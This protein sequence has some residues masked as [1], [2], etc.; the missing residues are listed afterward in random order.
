[1]SVAPDIFYESVT[2]PFLKEIRVGNGI[3]NPTV[4]NKLRQNIETNLIERAIEGNASAFN[5]IYLAL[6]DSIYGFSYRML[7][8]SSLAE[9]ITQEAFIFFIE[10]PEKYQRERGSLLSFLCGYARNRIMHLLRKQGSRSEISQDD[11]DDYIEPQNESGNDPLKILLNGELSAKIEESIAKLP[12][13]QRE[14]IVLRA[15]QEL[16]YEEIANIVEVDI[17]VVKMR[18]YRARRNLTV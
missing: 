2:F 15:M 3:N 16:T 8:E 7:G 1:M 10:H 17:T 5:E 18:L 13:L 14:V 4:L 6:R 12:A 11:A 9:D